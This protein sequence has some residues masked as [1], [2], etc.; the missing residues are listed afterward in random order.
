MMES[1][2]LAILPSSDAQNI[3]ELSHILKAESPTL[4]F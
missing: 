4:D 3:L 1:D 2:V